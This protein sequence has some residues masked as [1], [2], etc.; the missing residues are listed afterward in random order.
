MPELLRME[1]INQGHRQEKVP[2]T[3][4]VR[5][6]VPCAALVGPTGFKRVGTAAGWYS[7]HTYIVGCKY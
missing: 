5:P 2:G 7:G 4:S 1:M 3:I 6:A